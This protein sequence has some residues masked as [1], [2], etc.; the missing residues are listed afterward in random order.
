MISRI[1][2]SELGWLGA[3]SAALL[4]TSS[5]SSIQDEIQ[6]RAPAS[7]AATAESFVEAFIE[8]A[9]PSERWAGPEPLMVQF[10]A[11]D[12]DQAYSLVSQPTW[13]SPAVHIQAGA[14]RAPASKQGVEHDNSAVVTGHDPVAQQVIEGEGTHRK[15]WSADELRVRLAQLAESVEE[16]KIEYPGG[17]LYPVRIRLLRA[18]GGVVEKAGC[19][20]SRGWVKDASALVAAAY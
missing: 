8:Y 13:K 1:R 18:D 10:S 6:G 9:G 11:R 15:S 5:C 14:G 20:S 3:V 2:K 19:R 16:S 7:A 4:V 12:G 17:C